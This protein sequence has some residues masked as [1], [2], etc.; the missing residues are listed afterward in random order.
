MYK[1]KITKISTNPNAMRTPDMVGI[2]QELPK[3]GEIFIMLGE[4]LEFGTRCF[5]TS[6]IKS[7]VQEGN[8]F[9]LQTQNSVYHVENLGEVDGDLR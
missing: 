6:V 7:I 5:N 2:C 9:I 4:G 1:V 8:L 3:E